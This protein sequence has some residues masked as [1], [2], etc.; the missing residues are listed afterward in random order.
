MMAFLAL[1]AAFLGLP[2]PSILHE[3][4]CLVGHVL[5]EVLR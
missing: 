2:L 3:E 1:F 5:R 4:V